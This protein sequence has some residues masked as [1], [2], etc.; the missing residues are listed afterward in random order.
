MVVYISDNV[1]DYRTMV[2]TFEHCI[3]NIL[4]N[5]AVSQQQSSLLPRPQLKPFKGITILYA[6]IRV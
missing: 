2:R 4:H 1:E 3:S 6:H 5:K